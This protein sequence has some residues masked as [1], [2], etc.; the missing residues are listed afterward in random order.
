M[1]YIEF[2]EKRIHYR[3]YGMGTPVVFLHGLSFDSRMWKPQYETLAD[4][5]LLLGLDFRGHGFSNAP[6]IEYTLDT[7]VEDVSTVLNELHIPSAMVV[8]LSLG[9][10]VAME[11][12]L[13]YPRRCRGLALVS[14][15]MDDHS[16]SSAWREMM[17]RLH[18]CP[19]ARTLKMK[20][21]EYWLQDPMFEGIRGQLEYSRILQSMAETFSGKPILNGQFNVR[22]GRSVEHR[23]NRLNLPICVLSG[24]ADRSDFRRI[25]RT[26]G[27]NLTRVE[28]HELRG[29]G[30]MVNLE[31]PDQFNQLLSSFI[32]RVE[33]GGI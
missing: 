14:S 32:Y 7:Y 2:P 31:A 12:A 33:A 26:L 3:Q 17:K 22:N 13:R 25:A 19:D 11:F 4:N 6:E 23:L 24:S 29:I 10:A 30:H 16:W 8:G 5:F 27:S 21:R 9:G 1:P 28:W 18:D 20:L 15:A